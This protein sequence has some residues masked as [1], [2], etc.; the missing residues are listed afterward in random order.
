MKVTY[1]NFNIKTSIMDQIKATGSII[2]R[3]QDLIMKYV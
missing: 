2:N 3:V 1:L